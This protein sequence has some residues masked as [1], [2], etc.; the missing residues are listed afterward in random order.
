MADF[1]FGIKQEQRLSQVQVMSQRQIQSLEILSLGSDELREKIFSEV[2]RNP[3]LEIVRDTPSDS[4]IE[5]SIKN[6]SQE[7]NDH[8]AEFTSDY[9]H[10]ASSSSSAIEASDKFNAMIEA[11]PDERETLQDHFLSEL[12]LLELDN[13]T[14]E[15]CTLIIGNLDSKGHHILAP[16]SLSKDFSSEEGEKK[17]QSCLKIIQNIEPVGCAVKDVW[18]SLLVQAK[19]KGGYNHALYFLLDG[20]ADM[21]NPPQSAKVLKKISFYRDNIRKLFGLPESQEAILKQTELYTEKDIDE[22]ISFIKTLDPNPASQFSS[23]PSS[24]IEPDVKVEKALSEEGEE[25]YK[26]SLSKGLLPEVAVTKDFDFSN[27]GKF[28]KNTIKEAKAFLNEIAFREST[29]LSAVNEIVKAQRAF[30]DKGPRYL[31]PL[32][33]KNIAETIGVHE[34][35]ISRMASKKYLQCEWGLFELGYFF[36]NAVGGESS[37]TSQE[38]VKVEIEAIL[39]EHAGDKKPLSDQK[40]ADI[41]AERGIKI[42]RRTV[43]KYRSSLNINSSYTR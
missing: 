31:S 29:L 13:Q 28:A 41:L 6:L 15:Y 30:F 32:T 39:K 21:L 22:A 9:E 24:Y 42:A 43:A 40:I 36:T 10:Y 18:E 3:A 26:I 19:I 1:G 34:A 25:Y 17:L 2:E 33:Q 37:N 27:G 4:S 7:K 20:H 38:G 12:N 11:T 35:T 5:S 14:K 23:S 8:S 16:E